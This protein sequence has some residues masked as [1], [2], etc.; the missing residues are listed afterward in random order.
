MNNTGNQHNLS[1]RRGTIEDRAKAAEIR[2]KL[3]M[4]MPLEAHKTLATVPKRYQAEW[5]DSY[6]G[7]LG[8]KAAIKAKCHDCVG[9]EEIQERVGNCL[10]RDCALWRFRPHQPKP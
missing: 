1:I 6:S 3:R 8:P 7:V 9:Y 2:E 4:K 5:I 10:S